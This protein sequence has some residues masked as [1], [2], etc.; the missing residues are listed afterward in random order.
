MS[1]PNEKQQKRGSRSIKSFDPREAIG[2]DYLE[3]SPDYGKT[4]SVT[5]QD[6]RVVK[7]PG[8]CLVS[9]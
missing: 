6:I 7:H 5:L 2:A 3:N 8:I 4:S 9:L 1:E